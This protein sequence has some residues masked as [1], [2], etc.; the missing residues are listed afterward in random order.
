M[1]I[2][3]GTK[4]IGETEI[5]DKDGKLVLKFSSDVNGKISHYFD[6]G[7]ITYVMNHRESRIPYFLRTGE[8]PYITKLLSVPILNILNRRIK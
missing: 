3:N 6:K 5:T 7:R 2:F 4:L 8:C 1:F